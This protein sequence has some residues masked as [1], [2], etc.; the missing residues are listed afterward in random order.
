METAGNGADALD[1]ISK[2]PFDGVVTD[3]KM[4]GDMDGID[5]LEAVK[6]ADRD[7]EVIL[8]TSH[9][10]VASAV[11]AMKKGAADYLQKPVNFEELNLRLEKIRQMKSLI[12][13]ADD[14]REAMDITENK[15]GQTIRELEMMVADL[16]S[17]LSAMEKRLAEKK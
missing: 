7:T 12:K 14:L 15:A 6:A 3:L 11:T 1:L 5:L 13:D 16:Q 17:R 10:T 9:A 8:M 2:Y 4:P